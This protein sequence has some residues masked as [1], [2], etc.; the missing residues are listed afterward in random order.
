[1]SSLVDCCQR[2]DLGSNREA[3]SRKLLQTR[4]AIAAVTRPAPVTPLRLVQ[5]A[6]SR[7]SCD[8]LR[9]C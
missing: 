9:D 8:E 7:D 6:F 3:W 5:R 1:M 2:F 4:Q